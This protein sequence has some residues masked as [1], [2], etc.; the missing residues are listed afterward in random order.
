[1]PLEHDSIVVFVGPNSAGKSQSLRDI[2]DLTH[3]DR[4]PTGVSITNVGMN[5][6]GTVE[7]FKQ[8]LNENTIIRDKVQLLPDLRIGLKVNLAEQWETDEF[9]HIAKVFIKLI[10]AGDRLSAVSDRSRID[11]SN[12]KPRSPLQALDGDPEKELEVSKSFEKIFGQQLAL[13]RGVGSVVNLHVGTRP[14]QTLYAGLL[15]KEYY[16]EVRKL[17]NIDNEGD[18]FKSAAGL[19]LHLL[20]LPRSVYLIDEPDVYLHPPQAY[21][22]AK[23]LIRVSTKKQLFLATH[24]AH[25]IQGLLDSN[26]QRLVL[27]RLDRSAGNQAVN[28]INSAE[29]KKIKSD[30]LIKFSSLLE[31]L[32]FRTVI[33]C[34]NE[35][36]CLF[37]RSIYRA[38]DESVRDEN[39]FWV[40]AHAQTQ[41][42]EISYTLEKVWRT[43]SLA[44][45]DL[46]I[47]NDDTNLKAL[48]ASH[49]GDWGEF[50]SDFKTI[51][52][53]MG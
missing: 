15:H 2:Q 31:A 51:A 40:S 19:L 47:I 24:N 26:E 37:Y 22:A 44:L 9:R 13:D 25:F 28:V 30:P 42:K 33:V 11:L 16:A 53:L 14:A 6:I 49:G 7:E 1:M 29:F 20:G 41:Y 17:R 27:I 48:I 39:V 3:N 18:G 21:A 8:F 35:A 52:T 12:E 45:P 36:D 34:E 50:E 38:V 4:D 46:D 32:F 23:E 43:G 5:K 10:A